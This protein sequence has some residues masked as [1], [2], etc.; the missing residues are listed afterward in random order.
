[1]DMHEF[2][3]NFLRMV[4]KSAAEKGI[5]IKYGMPDKISM[6]KA[7]VNQLQQVLL[8]LVRNAIDAI[9]SR[10]DKTGGHIYIN[11]SEK[12]SQISIKV[13]DD[14]CGISPENLKNV[15]TPFYS[16]KPVGKGTGLGLSVCFGII[17]KMG[18]NIQVESEQNKGAEFV[19]NLPALN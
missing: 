1:M 13:V 16:T 18:G 15:F 4:N 5:E 14:G 11:V 9:D 10:E 17:E 8:N 19:I 12:D 2:I 3:P 7:D 6:L